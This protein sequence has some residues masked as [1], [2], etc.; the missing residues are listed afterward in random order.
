MKWEPI[1]TAPK[2]QDILL[3][4]WDQMLVGYWEPSTAPDLVAH[5]GHRWAGSE[6]CWKAVE[7][8]TLHKDAVTHWMPLPP[9]PEVKA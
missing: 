3:Y 4:G 9:A 6:W 1:E 7:G 2:D 8:G 5:D